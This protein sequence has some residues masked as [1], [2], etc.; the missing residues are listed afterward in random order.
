[1]KRLFLSIIFASGFLL[2][3]SLCVFAENFTYKVYN[4]RTNKA[5]TAVLGTVTVK[6]MNIYLDFLQ[7]KVNR[8]ALQTLI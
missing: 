8:F 6:T 3:M 1:M 2:N 4:P 7:R 5:Y